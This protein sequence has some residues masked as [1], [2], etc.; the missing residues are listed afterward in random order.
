MK[1]KFDLSVCLLYVVEAVLYFVPYCLVQKFWGDGVYHSATIKKRDINIFSVL[2]P[3]S[4]FLA[5][6]LLVSAV[7]VV[8]IYLLRTMGKEFKICKYSLIFSIVHTVI[9]AL[10]YFY[11]SEF[12]RVI[13]RE[14]GYTFAYSI[15]WL[16]YVIIALNVIA[17]VLAVLIKFGVV[18]Q[19]S[20]KVIEE[21]KAR[22]NAESI[23]DL[24]AYKELLDTGV[25][26][27]EEFDAKKKQLLRLP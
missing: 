6:L 10:F 22:K 26:T 18:R 14:F 2:P 4:K 13:S 27:Q 20:V 24:K 17:L 8:A 19:T 21:P 9:T 7:T 5:I 25:I 16:S 11:T 1:S 15:N 3:L 12:A 23:D